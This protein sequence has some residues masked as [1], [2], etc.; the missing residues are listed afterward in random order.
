[1]F[2]AHQP[3]S[4]EIVMVNTRAKERSQQE[5][6]AADRALSIREIVAEIFSYLPWKLALRHYHREVPSLCYSTAALVRCGLVNRIWFGQAI[7][8]LWK[9]IGDDKKQLRFHFRKIEL[10]CRQIY[11]NFVETCWVKLVCT[12]RE[13]QEVF[14]NLIFHNLRSLKIPLNMHPTRRFL[15]QMNAPRLDTV[16][17]Y[18]PDD[19]EVF[20]GTR[21]TKNARFPADL[22]V[23]RAAP[24]LSVKGASHNLT[25][26]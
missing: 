2:V 23:R 22:Q 26:F 18:I 24:W 8:Y 14:G 6:T 7:C 21:E 4:P 9:H 17:L 5:M 20:F 19:S 15:P 13:A 10:H 16:E 1:M 3:A 25:W 12:P 11:V